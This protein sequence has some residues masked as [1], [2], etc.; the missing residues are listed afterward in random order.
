MREWIDLINKLNAA[1]QTSR[2]A[3]R[4]VSEIVK[5][6]D[7]FEA[8]GTVIRHSRQGE[9]RYYVLNLDAL[10]QEVVGRLQDLDP[11]R[12]QDQILDILTKSGAFKKI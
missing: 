10:D 4:V 1:D 11:E 5:L 9:P 6:G 8:A 3:G 2:D 7:G 12:D